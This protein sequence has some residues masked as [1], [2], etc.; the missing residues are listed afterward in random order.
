MEPVLDAGERSEAA[1]QRSA[2]GWTFPEE[3][4]AG[5]SAGDGVAADGSAGEQDTPE[6]AA[7]GFVGGI[8][9]GDDDAVELRDDA[10]SDDASGQDADAGPDDLDPDADIDAA[11]DAYF[12]EDSDPEPTRAW[13][14]S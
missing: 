12:A 4:A 14:L 3:I 10:G 2:A 6:V 7:F 11:F 9:A 8:Q 5:G 1:P 13:M